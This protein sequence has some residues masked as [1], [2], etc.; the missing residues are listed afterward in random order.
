M[1][2]LIYIFTVIFL[3]SCVE[4]KIDFI[5]DERFNAGIDYESKDTIL[6]EILEYGDYTVVTGVSK[7]DGQSFSLYLKNEELY[8]K[9]SQDLLISFEEL[10]LETKEEQP[11]F[12][13][14]EISCGDTFVMLAEYNGSKK[15]YK[16]IELLSYYDYL[17]STPD[18][19]KMLIPLSYLDLDNDN[20]IDVLVNHLEIN[21]VLTPFRYS[22]TVFYKD[23]INLDK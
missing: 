4:E 2:K 7:E 12:I 13:Y 17:L 15:A 5:K 14:F 9:N 20:H 6:P 21:D 8:H 10:F 18:T 16:E 1:K 23:V 22:D 19:M 3:S 11:S